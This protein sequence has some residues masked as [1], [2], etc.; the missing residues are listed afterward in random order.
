[1]FKDRIREKYDDL[2]P[3]YRQVADYIINNTLEVAF[4]T[5][6]EVAQNA[7]VDSATVVRFAQEIGYSGSRELLSDLKEHIRHQISSS[8][9]TTVEAGSI[10]E[11]AQGAL[12]LSQQRLQRFSST[13]LPNLTEAA[14][15]LS[16]ADHIWIVG[17]YMS[18][19]IAAFLVKAFR[20]AGISSSLLH[21]DK[22]SL[23]SISFQLQPEDV[24]LALSILDP[25][26]ETSQAI[27]MAREKGIQTIAISGSSLSAPA[28]E[29]DISI[30]VPVKNPAGIPS[31]SALFLIIALVWEVVTYQQIEEGNEYFVNLRD[32]LEFLLTGLREL[33]W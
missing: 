12:E 11:A 26:L 22:G 18:Y 15:V 19:D 14:K 32:E 8:R 4:L 33:P 27:R 29:A 28:R 13:E 24:L 25:G 5:A 30:S 6:T 23:M 21:P 7:G 31:F 16:Q 20:L 2:T 1:M 17:E 9:R 10:E 3:G